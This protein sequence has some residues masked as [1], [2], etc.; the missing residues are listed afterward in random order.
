MDR[1][2]EKAAI[3]AWLSRNKATTQVLRHWRKSLPPPGKAHLISW[4]GAVWHECDESGKLICGCR[5]KRRLSDVE[6]R[7]RLPPL[8][9]GKSHRRI[10]GT[11]GEHGNW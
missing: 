10:V 1:D 7:D 2:D 4:T 5:G 8:L 9:C 11:E 3:D 6:T